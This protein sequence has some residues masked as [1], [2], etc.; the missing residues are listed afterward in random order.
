MLS[1]FG[2]LAPTAYLFLEGNQ[3]DRPIPDSIVEFCYTNQ[4]CD[5]FL[6]TPSPTSS[7][8]PS[9]FPSTS[10]VPTTSPRPTPSPSLSSSPTSPCP[11]TNRY[12]VSVQLDLYGAE[13]SWDI[14]DQQGTVIDGFDDYQSGQFYVCL[15]YN[16]NGCLDDGS[17]KFNLYDSY[18]DGLFSPG[19]V[20]L[21][22]GG[23]VVTSRA[24]RDDFAFSNLTLVEFD[25]P[26]NLVV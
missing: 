4:V 2:V 26:Y 5:P 12:Q 11:E 10:S 17:Y 23:V 6:L 15:T 25:V 19:Y 9:T 20:E 14:Q 18:G 8:A 16:E 3:F 24:G 1:S 21:S 7:A 13:T 22:V